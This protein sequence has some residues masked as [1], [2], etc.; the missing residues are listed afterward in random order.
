MPASP[1]TRSHLAILWFRQ[2]LR[3]ADNAAL[4]A[5]LTGADTILPIYILNDLAPPN[6]DRW[7]RLGGAAAW[8]LHDSLQSLAEAL[9]SRGAK[10]CLRRGDPAEILASLAQQTKAAS[11][12][13]GF[14]AEPGWRAQDDRL[15]H[16]LAETGTRLIR[17]QNARLFDPAG[18]KTKTGGIYGMFTPFAN[19]TA[20][21]GDPPQPTPAPASIPA[22]A[23]PPH[24]D[25]L[26]S[27]ELRPTRPDWAGG[28]RDTWTPGEPAAQARAA[29]FLKGAA[30]G[31]DTGRNL[32]GQDL[33][34]RLSPHLHW[35][36]ISPAALWHAIR[37]RKLGPG[38]QTYLRELVWR[39]F[40][41][42]LLWHQPQL[43]DAALR[44]EFEDLPWR[45]DAT[46]LRAWQRGQTGVPIVDA[47]MRQLWQIG[48]M[49]NRV[50]MITAS[51]LVKHLLIDWR[52][53]AAWFWDTLVDADLASNS[54]NWQWVAGT[55]I[56]SQP[57]FRVFN[58]VTQGQK[59]DPDGAYV[60][61]YVPELAD[62]P[63]RYLHAPWTAPADVLQH[64]GVTLGRTYP[65]PLIDLNA[66]R[67][68]ALAVYRAAAKAG[69][70]KAGAGKVDEADAEPTPAGSAAV[71]ATPAK[72]KSAKAGTPRAGAG[73]R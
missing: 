58:P 9:A 56:D 46:G 23:K 12:H 65:A 10:L 6:G 2:D 40:A 22:P 45:A 32:P 29:Q 47:G 19:A 72:A 16:L 35:G 51:Y 71:T 37:R 55:G 14:C 44:P 62:L 41:G 8:W 50:R 11:I 60:R 27:W 20:A 4:N 68:R 53:G 61:E 28:L 42:Y 24:S 52:A 64:A 67:E 70:G 39:D 49:H 36:E 43:A 31:Y 48:W 57:F 17:H 7:D 25:T 34:S 54:T 18:I 63:D 15:E 1:P 33:T 21:L 26:A 73:R 38:E 5:A 30:S 13:A 59:F 66:G 69:A 3:L